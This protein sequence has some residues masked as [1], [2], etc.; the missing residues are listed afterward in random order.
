M[1]TSGY[2]INIIVMIKNY[3]AEI[4][5]ELN[6]EGLHIS[7]KVFQGNIK[8]LKYPQKTL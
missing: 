4:I 7:D 8:N 2:L 6:R 1:S 3:Y 5:D